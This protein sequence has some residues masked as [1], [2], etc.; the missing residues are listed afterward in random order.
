VRRREFITLLGGA[1]AWPFAARA[2]Q[3]AMPM[4]G[5][6]TGLS[7]NYVTG[8]KP[9]FRRGL[10]EV[11]YVEG[12]NVVVEYHSVEGQSDRLS[13]VVT[14]LIERK[15]AVIVAVGGTDPAKAAKAE[16]T[17]I[18]IVFISAADP[19]GAGIVTR[20]NR[21]EGNITGVSILGTSLEAKRL[22]LLHDIVLGTSP[23]GVLVNPRFSDA[24]LE[25][26]EVEEA[27]GLVRR[28]IHV[29]HASAES[30]FEGAFA[31]LGRQSVGGLLI[32]SDPF[33]ASHREQLVALAA[34]YKLPTMYHQ[35]EFAEA[36]GL[37]SYAPD[38]ADGYRQ[39]GVYA[40]K[41]LKGAKPGDLPVMQSSK[42]ELVINLKTAR[43]LGLTIP[44]GVLSIADEV[45][46]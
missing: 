44:A 34:R 7:S 33:F 29:V 31:S 19:L 5:F 10:R 14:D 15:V 8:R 26:R 40:G 22:G 41:I 2:Q 43:T 45:I 20:L 17:T 18:P 36:G 25:L 39:G 35:R 13:G 23:I 27:T 12:Q 9:A 1:A 3:P 24:D 42:F 28:Q 38:F 21:P 37:V 32:A 30:E 6:V 46:E 11:G 4:V 16:T